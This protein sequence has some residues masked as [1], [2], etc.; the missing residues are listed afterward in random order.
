[1]TTTIDPG[2]FYN[3]KCRQKIKLDSHLGQSPWTHFYTQGRVWR[4]LSLLLSLPLWSFWD[5]TLYI[6]PALHITGYYQHK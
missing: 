6:F 1:M 3:V 4:S 2:I 5:M